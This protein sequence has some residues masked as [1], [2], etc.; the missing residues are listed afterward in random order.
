MFNK[1]TI[2]KG[3][4]RGIHRFTLIDIILARVRQLGMA[5]M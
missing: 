1:L 3:S 4:N 2:I 5:A